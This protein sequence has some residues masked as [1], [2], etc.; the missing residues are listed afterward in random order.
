MVDNNL[1]PDRLAD[2][3]A[4]DPNY[5]RAHAPKTGEQ[6]WNFSVS[7]HDVSFYPGN[8]PCDKNDTEGNNNLRFYSLNLQV[9]SPS[10]NQTCF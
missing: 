4:L 7:L 10:L 1:W 2:P 8:D 6:K 3:K 9:D 5:F